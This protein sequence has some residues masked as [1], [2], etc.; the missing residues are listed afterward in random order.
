MY[1]IG[2]DIG[3]TSTRVA[4][5]DESF[6]I[7]EKKVTSTSGKDFIDIIN[8]L[9]EM[10]HQV[11]PEN[12]SKVV[13][14]CSAGPI[15]N[16]KG[17][18]LDAPNLPQW[19]YKPFV[20]KIRN[21]TKRNV[22]FTNDANAAAIAQ[23]V[24]DDSETLVFITVSTGV[25]GGIVYKG[26]LME[27]K[28]VYAG[29]FGLMIIADDDRNHPSLYAGTLESLCSG[30][31]LGKEASRRFGREMEARDLFELYHQKDEIAVEI[32]ELWIEHFSRAIANLIL[33]IEPDVF[34]LGG[35]VILHNNFLIDRVVEKTK[36]KLYEGL[37]D[38]INIKVALF[39]EDAGLVGAAKNAVVNNREVENA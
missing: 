22:A 37:K 9:I 10:I 20:D 26:E 13:G 32:V 7:I 21:E 12:K 19:R 16:K 27:G 38:S 30:T 15:D 1:S 36:D 6:N 8:E 17:M 23:A 34:Y 4:L 33:T 28:K 14:I 3:G 25:G 18:V 11:D 5:F 35:S 2:V 31:A 29:E 24:N 39:G